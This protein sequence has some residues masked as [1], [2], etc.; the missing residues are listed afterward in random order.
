MKCKSCEEIFEKNS[1]LEDHIELKHEQKEKYECDKCD[2]TFVLK[3]RLT[4]HQRNHSSS[5]SKKCHF[6]NNKK[7]CPF[8]KIGCMF[9]HVVSEQCFF[10][11]K[12]LNNLCSYQHENEVEIEEHE[13]VLSD[14]FD[15]L[16]FKEQ[17]ES[18]MILC[19]KLCKPSQVWQ[20]QIWR[21]CWMWCV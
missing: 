21:I 8:E 2:K 4:K 9:D 15:E 13:K 5:K 12:C 11:R 6:F 7:P 19:D 10:G 20:W 1:D 17:N 3:W 14:K 16:T 18:R